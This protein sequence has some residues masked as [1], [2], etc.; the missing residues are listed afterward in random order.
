MTQLGRCPRSRWL[1][2][3]ILGLGLF[4]RLYGLSW[5][6]GYFFHPDER[7]ILMVTERLSL[8]WPPDWPLLWSPASPWN[9]RFFAYGSL[10]LYLL[11]AL[12]DLLVEGRAGYDT[13]YRV[14]R[15]LSALFDVG[16]IA[17]VYLL[18]EALYERCVG[19]LGAALCALTVLH[20]QLS[21]F[22]AVDTLLALCV[23]G[24]VLLAV[25]VVKRPRLGMAAPLGVA[26]GAALATKISAAPL[27]LTIAL[28]WGWGLV[29]PRADDS[30]SSARGFATTW[31]RAALGALL[32]G[33]A[34]L[35]T[36]LL[37]Q[38]YAAID[39]MRFGQAVAQ[40]GYMARGQADIPYTRQYIGTLP[41]IYPLW[42]LV[43]WSLGVP[44]GL[45]CLAGWAAAAVHWVMLILR[46]AW[47]RAGS[48][49]M[50]L[51]WAT[52]Y[53]AL[54][55]SFHAKFL[56]YMLPIVPFL[57]V[58]AGWALAALVRRA[59]ARTPHRIVATAMLITV[60]AGA[61]LYSLAYL[62]VY[63]QD[64]TWLQAT[65]W[66]CENLPP[67]ARVMVEH[68]DDPLPLIQGR[69]SRG[70]HQAMSLHVFPAYD[71]DGA[72]KLRLLVDALE[73]SDYIVLSTNRLYNTIPRLP[74][75]YPITSRYYKLLLGEEL[76]YELVYYAAVYPELFG[77]RLVNDT[78][79]DPDLPRPRLLALGEAS[80]ISLNLGRADE[81]YTVYDHPMPLVFRK[82][83][84][85]SRETLLSLLEQGDQGLR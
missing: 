33:F 28:A 25:R 14:G 1:L 19:L 10:P 11:R 12:S 27:G 61:G 39:V 34:A 67:G 76:G 81:S 51:S 65:D 32:T 53:F 83:R 15:T 52:I 73:S 70:C 3:P 42:Q 9:P 69:G 44:L 74:E 6:E 40:E 43:V 50:P 8:P 45:A 17:L 29:S 68:W 66:L 46:D 84:P 60:L 13:L 4:L 31:A 35:A 54:V 26:W 79:S 62:N 82:T 58:W 36:F 41:Y 56:R 49:L 75:R 22:Y 18:G 55:G 57:C 5:D 59:G 38:P 85:L 77:V 78:F 72:A 23:L 16:T 80:G 71:P 37:L 30:P 48:L 47:A 64:H 7:Q 24:T 2:L 20:I 21:H 63:R